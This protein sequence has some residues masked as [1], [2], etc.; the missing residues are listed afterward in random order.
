MGRRRIEEEAPAE[1]TEGLHTKYRPK[2]LADVVGQAAVT[3]SLEVLIKAK[4]RQHAFMFTG[5][6]GT[7]KTTL[8]RIIAA[9]FGCADAGLLEFDA[10]SKSGVDDIREVL[11]G[12]RYN[13]FGAS[14]NKAV[15]VDECHRLS[16]NAW[17]ALL[18]NVEEPPPHVFF[19]FCSTEPDK[20][21]AAIVTRCAA[22]ALK[23]VRLDDLMDLLEEIADVEGLEVPTKIISMVAQAAEGSPRQAITMLAKVQ[24]VDDEDEAAELLESAMEDAE[25][26]DLCR[27]MLKRDL[28][29]QKMVAVVKGL[30]EPAE[31][32]RIVI[33]NYLAGCLMNPRGGDK[34]ITR[35]LDMLEVFSKPFNASD[36][37]APLLVAFGRVIFPA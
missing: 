4:S 11:S 1:A 35:I 19:F 28:E 29:W 5:P 37:L 14:P 33:A 20:I 36:K 26:I 31:T 2:R 7:G 22:Y 15:I 34:E 6:A 16:K 27:L 32:I 25:I 17:D 12:L 30:D 24:G 3:K 8:A 21:P 23:P 9:E 18:K 10:A 13:G